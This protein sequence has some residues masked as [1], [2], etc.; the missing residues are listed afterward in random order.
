VR[1]I[2]ASTVTYGGVPRAAG[3][4]AATISPSQIAP[5]G[6]SLSFSASLYVGSYSFIVV[7]PDGRSTSPLSL[8]VTPASVTIPVPPTGLSPGGSSPPG[9]MVNTLTP[10]LSWNASTSATQY[11]VAMVNLST[12]ATAAAQRVSTTSLTTPALQNGVTYIWNVSASNSAGTSA[13]SP[14][15][16]FTASVS[17][18]AQAPTASTDSASAITSNSATLGGT[19]NPNGLS[20]QIWFLYGTNSSLVGASQT[21]RQTVG[22][23]TSS[24][25]V[26][27]NISSLSP[28]TTY[29]Y[30][31]RAQNSAGTSNGAILSFATAPSVGI[32]ISSVSVTPSSLAT[33]AFAT[34]S[35]TIS[36]LALAGGASV[37]IQTSNATAFP[38]P[39]TITIPAGQSTN[40][41]PVQA[42]TVTTSTAVTVTATYGGT[43]QNTTVTVTPS[44]INQVLVTPGI[45]QPQLTVG[46]APATLGFQIR[47]QNGPALNG[48]I[49]AAT[50]S[51]GS[52]L[53]ANGLT[54]YTWTAPETV[55]ATANPAGLLPGMYT[56]TLT[57]TAPAAS[58][59]PVTI[60]VTMTIL[61]ALQITTGSLP[62][63]IGGQPYSTQLQAA[64]GTGYMWSLEGGTL[65][66]GLTLSQSGSISGTPPQ[67]SGISTYSVNIGLHDAAS[68][69]VYKTLPITLRPGLA[70]T[71]SGPSS[72]QFVVGQLYNSAGN[73]ISFQASG[74]TGPYTWSATGMP[75]GLSVNLS[76]GLIAGTPTQPGT[77]VAAITVRDSLSVSFSA[78]FTL[79]VVTTP[80][81]I[82]NADGSTP[83]A[84][85]P[86]T[87]GTS[88]TRF[89]NAAGGTQSLYTWTTQG[90]LPPGLTAQN[91]P[92]CPTTCGLQVSGTPTQAGTFN[93]IVQ[94][95]DSLGNTAQ[96]SFSLIINSGIPP[97][98]TTTTLTL[99]TIGQAYNFTF[100]ASGG[101]GGYRWSFI[102]SGP[103]PGLQ[104]SSSGVLQGTSSV[105][106]DCPTG[107]AIWIGNQPPFGTFS[108]SYFQVQVTDSAGQSANK[109]FCLPA[110]YSMPQVA[111]VT[112]S[113]PADGQTH[114]LTITG[115]NFRNNASVYIQGK[116]FVS[117]TY[118]SSATLTFSITSNASNGWGTGSYTFWV[119]QPYANVSNMDKSFRIQ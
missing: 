43:S 31:L 85:P 61:S 54:S 11:S 115:S 39:S 29:Y 18:T 100:T 10:T 64:G 72:F 84:L 8:T 77:F 82:T 74:G 95:R 44:G 116:G 58:N 28:N 41:V 2:Y 117:A 71:L 67:V 118:V 56:G 104:L 101:A 88:Y 17:T 78:N 59:S 52:W 51:G 98:I 75:P 24:V 22:S 15:V 42:G 63:A 114:V 107:P 110:Y 66:V 102:A 87:V 99:G 32:T 62:D 96:Q 97:Q 27:A 57:V 30:Q 65:P 112:P 103:D 14:G 93:F 83:A 106:N 73:S 48:T 50:D 69:F 89:L 3:D 47:S 37:T 6:N 9:P 45:W 70:I 86:G 81:I 91:A 12:G 34:L 68:R 1:L 20:T 94:V 49:T 105:A 60:R 36:G 13:P 5:D 92:G 119:V 53:L 111:S 46:D 7:N 19:L 23:G 38:A 108:S 33:G 16:Y 109:Q 40:G 76:T 55:N 113:I 25:P 21:P 4:T 79:A 35:V 90:T 26:S 80:L